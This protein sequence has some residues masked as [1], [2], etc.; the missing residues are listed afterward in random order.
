VKTLIGELKSIVV[1]EHPFE[2]ERKKERKES[3]LDFLP[4]SDFAEEEMWCR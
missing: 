2:H 4:Q 1:L 3:D